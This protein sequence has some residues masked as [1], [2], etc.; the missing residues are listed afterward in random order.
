[1]VSRHRRVPAGLSCVSK[2]IQRR[3][4]LFGGFHTGPADGRLKRTAH[5]DRSVE[6]MGRASPSIADE[7]TRGLSVL[8]EA[9]CMREPRSQPMNHDA[10]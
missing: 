3:A 4:K 8:R 2:T 1:M 10:D 6:P 7:F 9:V 5:E